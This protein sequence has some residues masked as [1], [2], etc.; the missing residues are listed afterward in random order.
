MNMGKG[1]KQRPTNKTTFDEN[2]DR[3]FGGKDAEHTGRNKQ[4]SQ[5]KR[6]GR[7]SGDVEGDLEAE[8]EG[9]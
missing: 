1:S 8:K 7:S 2:F 4:V 9:E 6:I 5:E 3:I